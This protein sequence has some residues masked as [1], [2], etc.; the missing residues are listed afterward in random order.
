MKITRPFHPRKTGKSRRQRACWTCETGVGPILVA[1]R[2]RLLEERGRG[3]MGVV[4]RAHDEVLD[5]VVAVKEILLPLGADTERRREL[6]RSLTREARSMARLSHAGTAAVHDVLVAGGRPWLV[7]EFVDAP[8][9]QQ[10]IDEEGPLDPARAAEIGRQLCAVLRAAHA[11]GLLHRDV[12]P[13]NVLVCPDGRVVLTD[14][15][16]AIHTEDTDL[17]V[18]EGSPAYVSPEQARNDRLTEASDLWSLGVTLYTAVDGRPP[19]RRAGA[20]ASMLAVLVDEHT[21][22]RN[23]GPLRP[24]IDGLL[25]KDPA[26]R[27]TAAETARMLEKLGHPGPRL[28]DLLR[29]VRAAARA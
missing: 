17:K 14:F 22:P 25:R 13:S 2:Y 20:L 3:G 21:P 29:P 6:C 18:L 27:L 8:N 24:V 26:D 9:L 4:W 19:Y 5:R 16:L 12:K 11:A 28:L 23:A 1:G 15:G 7:M 10:V